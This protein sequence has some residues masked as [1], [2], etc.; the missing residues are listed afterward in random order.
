MMD[1]RA[2]KAA[3]REN[4]Q[5]IKAIYHASFSREDRMPFWMMMAMSHLWNTEFLAFYDGDT[6]CGFVYLATV[7]KLSFIMFL[8]VEE[9]LRSKGYGGAILQKVQAMHPDSKVIVSI[10]PCG[11][12]AKDLAQRIRRKNFYLRNGYAETGYYIKLGGKT[13]ELL[14][15]NGTFS[16]REF[17]LFFLLYSNFTMFPKISKSS[18]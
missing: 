3:K 15:R 10:E 2:K 1:L 13:Q 11:E 17:S 18:S 14:V 4:K 16:K 6:L 12:I 5:K 7:R 9:T 8:A